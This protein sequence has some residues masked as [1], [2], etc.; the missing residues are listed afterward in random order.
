MMDTIRQNGDRLRCLPPKPAN[1]QGQDRDGSFCKHSIDRALSIKHFFK[2]HTR[3]HQKCRINKLRQF[4]QTLTSLSRSRPW[5]LAGFGGKHRNLTPFSA[6]CIHHMDFLCP[7]VHLMT[8]NKHYET[9]ARAPARTRVSD[10]LRARTRVFA[11]GVFCPFLC[12]FVR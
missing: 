5:T 1:V 11:C 9:Y 6:Y 12:P 4:A 7:S 8:R 2:N 3:L 10:R